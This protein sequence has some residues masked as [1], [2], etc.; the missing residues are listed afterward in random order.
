MYQKREPIEIMLHWWKVQERLW[1]NGGR[2]ATVLISVC[3]SLQLP[4]LPVPGQEGHLRKLRLRLMAMTRVHHVLLLVHLRLEPHFALPE[5]CLSS[6]MHE[7]TCAS[8]HTM[9][10]TAAS[11]GEPCCLADYTDSSAESKP[12]H[13]WNFACPWMLQSRFPSLLPMSS[14]ASLEQKG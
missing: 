10:V 7:P 3:P 14:E 1:V 13:L 8:R 6:G 5:S 12:G 9:V 2:S 4:P 11:V